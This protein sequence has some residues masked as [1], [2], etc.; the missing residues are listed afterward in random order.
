MAA[1]PEPPPEPPPLQPEPEDASI[2]VAAED[3]SAAPMDLE[4]AEA[5]VTAVAADLDY[6]EVDD[7]EEPPQQLSARVEVEVLRREKEELK[8]AL[9]KLTKLQ[10]VTIERLEF[11]EELLGPTEAQRKI[12]Q[13]QVCAARAAALQAARDGCSV[14]VR[15]VGRLDELW[16]RSVGLSERDCALLQRGCVTGPEGVPRDVSMLGD[17]MFKPYDDKT[18]EPLWEARGGL[19]RLSLGDVRNRWGEEVALEV[20]KCAVELDRHDGSRRLGVELPWSEGE[21]RELEPCEVIELL[22]RELAITRSRSSCSRGSAGVGLAPGSSLDET[23]SEVSSL[24]LLGGDR[25]QDDLADSAAWSIMDSETFGTGGMDDTT[26]DSDEFASP[27]PSS[28]PS[29]ESGNGPAFCAIGDYCVASDRYGDEWSLADADIEQLLLGAGAAAAS[30]RKSGAGA[31]A[32]GPGATVE[33][34]A[35]SLVSTPRRELP[36]MDEQMEE[37]GTTFEDQDELG[38]VLRE[39]LEEEVAGS[40]GRLLSRAP[41][42]P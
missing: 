29:D 3:E 36:P 35:R 40:L 42:P 41:R 34:V 16:L 28:V 27:R 32:A 15:F 30:C 33:A 39:L 13:D 7:V 4:A 18:Q 22:E 2:A 26:D 9:A 10:A 19:L 37:C 25:R 1:P 24:D 23:G 11:V 14:P 8:A 21:N 6:A 20:L 17:P 5:A 38:E 12:F 31:T